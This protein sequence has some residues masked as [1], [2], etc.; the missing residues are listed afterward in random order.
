MPAASANPAETKNRIFC[1]DEDDE[2]SPGA[3]MMLLIAGNTL[4]KLVSVSL[5]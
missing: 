4:S 2:P 1:G 3:A 5:A